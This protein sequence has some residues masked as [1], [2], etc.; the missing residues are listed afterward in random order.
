MWVILIKTHSSPRYCWLHL[1]K[2]KLIL[3]KDRWAERNLSLN[4]ASGPLCT[5]ILFQSKNGKKSVASGPTLHLTCRLQTVHE[6]VL[7]F[8]KPLPIHMTQPDFLVLTSLLCCGHLQ[9]ILTHCYGFPLWLSKCWTIKKCWTFL[10]PSILSLVW[11][12]I[13]T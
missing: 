9:L 13:M 11:M 1:L 4:L 3:Y 7:H 2:H 12:N 6:A 5:E 10:L 8:S